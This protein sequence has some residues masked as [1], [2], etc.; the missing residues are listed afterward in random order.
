M[1]RPILIVDDDPLITEALASLLDLKG[2][3]CSTAANGREAI[4]AISRQRPRLVFLD[5]QM[6]VLDGAS[7]VKELRARGESVP[8][9][10]MSAALDLAARASELG[11]PAYLSK[12]FSDVDLLSVIERFAAA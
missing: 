12:P 4:D 2:F 5:L 11:V 3:E 1:G 6:P 10:L 8:I 7:V 9:V